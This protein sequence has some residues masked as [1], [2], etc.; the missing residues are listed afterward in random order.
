ME[1]E[2]REEGGILLDGYWIDIGQ[3][4]LDGLVHACRAAGEECPVT[5][6]IAMLSN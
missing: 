5:K 3:D 6:L 4:V 1:W 2:G